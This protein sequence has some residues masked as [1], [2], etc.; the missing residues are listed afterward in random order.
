MLKY[1]ISEIEK[2]LNAAYELIISPTECEQPTHPKHPTHNQNV[3][4]LFSLH[5]DLSS[6][7][8]AHQPSPTLN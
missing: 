4:Q 5:I 2:K 8:I 6:D 3:T 1:R 7:Q